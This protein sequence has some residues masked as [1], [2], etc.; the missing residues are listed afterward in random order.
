MSD[1]PTSVGV[2][3]VRLLPNQHLTSSSII[4]SI[5]HKQVW[6][7]SP[8]SY[9]PADNLLRLSLR[10]V[11]KCETLIPL[12]HTPNSFKMRIIVWLLSDFVCYFLHYFF[13]VTGNLNF[14]LRLSFV[15]L[16]RNYA[17]LPHSKYSKRVTL[18]LESLIANY[19]VFV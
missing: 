10:M 4:P 13:S 9:I 8:E 1:T 19:V 17:K 5:A 7:Q 12:H 6:F 18:S 14:P 11:N 16:L 2:N 3:Y 15:L